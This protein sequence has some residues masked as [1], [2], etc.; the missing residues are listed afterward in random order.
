MR[1]ESVFDDAEQRRLYELRE[2]MV[3][4]ARI[5]RE[6]LQLVVSSA[7]FRNLLSSMIGMANFMFLGAFRCLFRAPPCFISPCF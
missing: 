5:G 2:R 6:L 3:E 1:G 7:E 4:T